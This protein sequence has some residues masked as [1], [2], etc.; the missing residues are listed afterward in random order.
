MEFFGF[1]PK[2]ACFLFCGLRCGSHHPQPMFGL[3]R[4]FLTGANLETKILFFGHRVV[5]LT[6]IGPHAGSGSNE[7]ANQR[8]GY[9]VLRNPLCELYDRFTKARRPFFHV[10]TLWSFVIRHSSFVIG[11]SSFPAGTWKSPTDQTSS[12]ELV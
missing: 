6:I 8:Q 12:L 2:G 1:L 3:S 9:R 5:G 11:T 4:L 10:E 7:L